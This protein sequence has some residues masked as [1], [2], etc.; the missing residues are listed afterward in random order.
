MPFL[1][2]NTL[3]HAIVVLQQVLVEHEMVS[4]KVA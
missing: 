4:M 1:I 2:K 3:V